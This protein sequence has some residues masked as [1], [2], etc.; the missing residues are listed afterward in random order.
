MSRARR[1]HHESETKARLNWGCN[2]QQA[3]SSLQLAFASEFRDSNLSLMNQFRLDEGG[4][5]VCS[6][7]LELLKDSRDVN[8]IK[9]Q[10]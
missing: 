6:E 8:I 5:N 10:S 3:I 9:V 1:H 2:G 7:N 4:K